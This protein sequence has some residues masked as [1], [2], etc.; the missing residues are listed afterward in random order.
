MRKIWRVNSTRTI[1]LPFNTHFEMMKKNPFHLPFLYRKGS[2]N[3]GEIVNFY[4]QKTSYITGISKHLGVFLFNGVKREFQKFLDD[5]HEIISFPARNPS[6]KVNQLFVSK[7]KLVET[8]ITHAY[9]RIAFV[10]GFISEKLYQQ[11][12]N[13]KYK[14]ARNMALS[15]CGTEK[16]YNVVRKGVVTDKTV[17]LRE[18]SKELRDI[19][20][21]IRLECFRI[22]FDLSIALKGEWKEYNTDGIKYLDTEKNRKI[23]ERLLKREKMLFRHKKAI[24]KPSTC[25][26]KGLLLTSKKSGV[27]NESR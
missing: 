11:G 14:L 20:T 3:N 22:M 23:V 18:E 17:V 13:E 15:T 8:D 24:K 27:S 6:R 4:G 21:Y 25:G 16:R 26:G 10:N 19:Y 12:C 5:G 7:K 2:D 1:G 9:W